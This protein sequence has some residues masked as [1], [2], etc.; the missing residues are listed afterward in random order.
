MKALNL[1]LT[2]IILFYFSNFYVYAQ[3]PNIEINSNANGLVNYEIINAGQQTHIFTLFGD[4]TFS[5]LQ[6]PKHKFDSNT[7]GYSTETY[8]ARA[9]DPNLPP[10]K[11]VQTGRVSGGNPYVNPIIKMTGDIDILTSWA[12]AKGYENFYII[13]FRN[14]TSAI[15]IKGCIEFLY[16][17]NEIDVNFPNI[18]VYN[19]WVSNRTVANIP[20]K[21][22]QKIKWDFTNLKQNETRY[23][24]VPAK[25]LTAIG[26]KINVEAKY[27]IN[28]G[29]NSSSSSGKFLSR[30]YPHDP[31]FKIVNRECI[32]PYLNE[33]QQLVY[34]IGFFNDGTDFAKD[35][36]VTDVLSNHLDEHSISLVDYEVQPNLIINNRTLHLD[37]LDLNLPGTNQTIPETYSY[38][39]AFSH[40]S[41]KICTQPNLNQCILNT[42]KIVFDTQLDFFTNTAIICADIEC[43]DYEIC[44]PLQRN[45]SQ[46]EPIQFDHSEIVT[47][48][49]HPN[50]ASSQI[51]IT[52]DFKSQK[53]TKFI[54]TLMNYSGKTI[55]ELIVNQHDSSQFARTFY[56]EEL[57]SGL[58]FMTLETEHER[59]TKKII[60]N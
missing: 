46:S 52:I 54:I 13:A 3:T 21:L 6:Q 29:A 24:Y 15:P 2:L 45:Q 36:Y 16:N 37:F 35:V 4:G 57:S 34:T 8:F 38:D 27:K 1:N 44:Q 41:F 59:F 47:F 7:V 5:S 48:N 51:D 55:K 19:T 11:T 60:K 56:L 40:V 31:N 22:N 23:I 14:T 30:R 18:K 9:Y 39:D 58:Y 28:C 33:Q 42:A 53:T 50:P 20:G 43:N 49:V 12:T 25:T 32:K 26:K 17:T 10:K